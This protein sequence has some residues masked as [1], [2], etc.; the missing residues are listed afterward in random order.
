MGISVTHGDGGI[1]RG[2][3]VN[4]PSGPG[5][6]TGIEV[7]I[8]NAQVVGNTVSGNFAD[9]I[10]V[11]GTAAPTITGNTVTGVSN[12]G[13]GLACDRARNRCASRNAAISGNTVKNAQLIGIKLDNDWSDGVVSK[14]T[15][16]RTAGSWPN[17]KQAHFSAIHQSPAPGKGTID[18]NIIVQDAARPPAG[19]DFCGVHVNSPMPGSAITN[20]VF[21]SSTPGPFGSGIV[22]NTGKATAGWII[23]KNSYENVRRP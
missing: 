18:S 17:D 1:I 22:D 15:I 16:T 20:N 7:I 12:I 9:G 2:N 23:D 3:K 4:N 21:R 13:I 6:N 8:A 10:L 11:I 14:N 19:F 5:Q